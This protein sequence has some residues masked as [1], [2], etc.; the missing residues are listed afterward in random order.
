MYAFQ[1]VFDMMYLVGKTMLSIFQ[2]D[3]FE[4]NEVKTHP[5]WEFPTDDE[6]EQKSDEEGSEASEYTSEDED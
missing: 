5:Q 3:V 2:F 4:A 1:R 6:K